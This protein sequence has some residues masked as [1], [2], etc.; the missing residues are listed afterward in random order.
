VH[1]TQNSV[2]QILEA[3]FPSANF[4]NHLGMLARIWKRY[5]PLDV[6]MERFLRALARFWK[7][8][9]QNQNQN[10]NVYLTTPNYIIFID[11]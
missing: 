3:G 5:A 11:I 9:F 7:V 6:R 10:Q 1:A 4:P 2:F 8:R